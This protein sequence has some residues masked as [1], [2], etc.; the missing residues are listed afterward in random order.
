MRVAWGSLIPSL[1]L[2]TLDWP[3]ATGSGLGVAS[4]L[5]LLQPLATRTREVNAMGAK[6]GS[7]IIDVPPRWPGEILGKAAASCPTARHLQERADLTPATAPK[8]ACARPPTRRLGHV[9][10]PVPVAVA[11][12]APLPLPPDTSP[13]AHRSESSS[14]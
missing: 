2:S 11:V 14:V 12:P 1:L 4:S 10:L 6:D 9:F 8:G 7:E 5:Q 3:D 13:R